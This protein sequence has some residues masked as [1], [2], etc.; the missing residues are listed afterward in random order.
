MGF[1][2]SVT[3]MC[4]E[5]LVAFGSLTA[6][7]QCC[8]MQVVWH[9]VS[10]HLMS[11]QAVR[12]REGEATFGLATTRSAA[13]GGLAP[14]GVSPRVWLTATSSPSARLAR[15]QCFSPTHHPPRGEVKLPRSGHFG[16]VL[17]SCVLNC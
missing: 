11:S 14:S 10:Q 9:C 8:T 6:F 17:L 7:L 4:V 3:F 1:R 13:V 12:Q 5:L 16:Q 15:Y 2:P